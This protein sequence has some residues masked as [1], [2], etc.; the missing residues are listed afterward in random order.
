MRLRDFI[1]RLAERRRL[2]ISVSATGVVLL[3]LGAWLRVGNG[4]AGGGPGPTETVSRR[5]F[6]ATVTAVGAVKPQIGAEVRVG[7]RIS[8]R[9][10][11][12][13]ANIGD[14]VRRGQVIAE[15]ETEELDAVIG[16]RQ[17]ELELAEAKL[18]A[19]D[20]LSPQEVARAEAD[21]ARFEA[22]AR[23]ATEERQRFETLFQ[24]GGATR[25]EV[26]VAR[27]RLAVAEAEL[28]SAGQSLE[29]ARTNSTELRKQ[30]EAERARASA[31]L[32]SARV[33]RS[34]TIILS[35][36]D[37]IVASVATQ[38]G[39]TV[40]AGLSA[41]TFVTIVDLDRL[42][43]NGYVDEV[44]IGRVAVGQRVVFTVDAHP[45]RDFKGRVSAI[46][47]TATIQ[48]NVVKYVVAVDIDED[49]G[50]LLRPEMTAN[51]QLYLEERPVLAVPA[52]AIRRE[53]GQ[54]VIYVWQSGRPERREVRLGWRDGAWVEIV[55][56]V[57]EGE[58]VLRDP[59]ALEE[60]A[61]R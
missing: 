1:R 60:G 21:V 27:E 53:A 38:E 40:A 31:S 7:S 56:G 6:A 13:R 18:V 12:L 46:Y 15:L 59:P 54:S 3:A 49:Y 19:L 2:V 20:R 61:S 28:A 55:E 23:L 48:D 16:Q 36:I 41:P 57:R 47:P 50:G 37:G 35:P 22:S 44:D 9:V 33:A 32:A 42:Q 34:F 30:A 10:R 11:R 5:T 14:A 52:R 8:G 58:R 43:V 51:V 26:D 39:E 29:L 25:A 4:R 45:S 24:S 17:A